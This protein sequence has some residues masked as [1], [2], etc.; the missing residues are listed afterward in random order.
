MRRLGLA[1]A[2]LPVVVSAHPALAEVE[3]Q[4]VVA[5]RKI[6]QQPAASSEFLAWAVRGKSD[7]DYFVKPTDGSRFRVDSEGMNG[8][9][10]GIDGTTLV[11]QE[12]SNRAGSDIRV[13]DLTTGVVGDPP[14]GVNTADWEYWPSI[15]G[16]LLLFG[17]LDEATGDRQIV[18]FDMATETSAVLDASSGPHRSLQPGQVAGAYVTW[19]RCSRN[20]CTAYVHDVGSATTTPVPN[21]KDRFQYAT[22]VDASGTVYL[23]ESGPTCGAK[24]RLVSSTSNGTRTVLVSLSRGIDFGD[25]YALDNGDGT[26]SVFFDPGECTPEGELATGDILKVVV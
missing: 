3:P 18:L 15:S 24:V 13:V 21:P 12:W 19:S 16:D 4:E 17:R 2:V 10:G 5:T 9:G 6:E 20:A 25:S 26:T 1:L 8:A 22:S 11:F 7:W 23:A 14:T